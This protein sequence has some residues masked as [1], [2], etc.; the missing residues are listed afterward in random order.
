MFITATIQTIVSGTP[1]QAGTSTAPRNGQ[2]EVVDPD[3]ERGRD[4][5][6]EHLAGE[7][8]DRFE[9]AEV[10]DRADD[11]RDRGAEQDAAHLVGEVEEGERR[12]DDPEEDR[13]PAEPRDRPPVETALV[14]PVDD[15]EQ[16]RHAADRGRQQDDDAEG[17]QGPV[18]DLRCRPQVVPHLSAS[19]G[20]DPASLG[21]EMQ[22]RLGRRERAYQ[23]ICTRLRTTHGA[24]DRG[25]EAR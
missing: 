20:G 17:D 12:D 25:R 16:P 13:E 1:I 6:R 5:R 3:A 8:R 9:T 15:A 10:V 24:A 22:A 14:G 18:Q 19:D 21:R 7:L 11:A 4:R 23:K 2:R